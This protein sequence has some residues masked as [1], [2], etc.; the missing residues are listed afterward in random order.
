MPDLELKDIAK[1]FGKVKALEDISLQVNHGEFTILLGPSGCGKSTLLRIIAGLESQTQG[2]VL[3][4]GEKVDDRSPRERDIAMVFQNYALYPHLEVHENLAFGLKMR[5]ETRE[6]IEA[7]IREAAQLLDIGD[8]LNRKPRE[9]SGGQ[10]QRVAMGRAIVRKPKLFLFDEPL[11]NLDARLRVLMRVELKKLHQRLGST[12]I[13]VTHDQTEAMTLGQKIVVMNRGRI[14]QVD[15]ADRIYSAPSSPF[16]A[17]FIGSPAMNLLHG[18]LEKKGGVWFFRC[19]QLVF[20]LPPPTEPI[21]IDRTE[22]AVLGIR[23]EDMQLEK[24]TQT[25]TS[26]RGEIEVVENLGSDRLIHVVA[27]D[28]RLVVRA[29]RSVQYHPGDS[30]T[31]HLPYPHLHLFIDDQ[32]VELSDQ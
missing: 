17:G 7:R 16:V 10:R 13:Y 14:Q 23:P 26:L 4:E 8:L 6:V 20:S 5:K 9:L 30:M 22:Q 28:Q 25:G 11:S 2:E 15:T 19:G 3:I 24:T 31:L 29:P 32:R 27:G 18:V 1:N 21:S 12:M